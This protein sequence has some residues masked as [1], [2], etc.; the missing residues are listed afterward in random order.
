MSVPPEN[1]FSE[2]FKIPGTSPLPNPIFSG[3][4][5][6]SNPFFTEVPRRRRGIFLWSRLLR[7]LLETGSRVCHWVSISVVRSL[8]LRTSR[9][10]RSPRTQELMLKEIFGPTW[11]TRATYRTSPVERDTPDGPS[12]TLTN[13]SPD[14]LV[15]IH[16]LV[17]GLRSWASRV[18]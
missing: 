5:S 12:E 17:P 11:P 7:F 13:T 14:F 16:K 15:S 10:D 2:V 18:P 4:T 3:P 9:T 1:P 6:Q 8:H